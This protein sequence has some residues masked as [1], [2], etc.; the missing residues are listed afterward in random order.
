MRA[1]SSPPPSTP[2]ASASSRPH[3][4]SPRFG[5]QARAIPSASR[6]CISGP[7][8]GN[9]ATFDPTGERVVTAAHHT[10][11]IWDAKT[12][13]PIGKP[14]EHEDTVNSAAFDPKGERVVTASA[15]KTA[16]IWDAST[17]YPSASRCGMR[18]RSIPPPST[19]MASAS[20]RPHWGSSGFGIFAL[21]GRL[22]DGPG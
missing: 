2:R 4:G 7:F 15:D 5:T 11:R 1:R 21:A 18:A 17:G 16:R 9:S 13:E 19:P 6:W 8:S 3:W 12:G 10:A 22:W 14:L 20:S